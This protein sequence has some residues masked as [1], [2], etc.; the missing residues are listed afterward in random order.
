MILRESGKWKKWGAFDKVETQHQNHV[1]LFPY[2][3]TCTYHFQKNLALHPCLGI[4]HGE[5]L[6]WCKINAQDRQVIE[7]FIMCLTMQ[8]GLFLWLQA[9]TKFAFTTLG[10]SALI[11]GLLQYKKCNCEEK[12]GFWWCGPLGKALG[13]LDLLIA[14]ISRTFGSFRGALGFLTSRTFWLFRHLGNLN[15]L[16]IWTLW[17]F[18]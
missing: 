13:H 17:A 9:C 8:E 10:S 18:W 4:Y 15:P 6:L 12:L 7:T 5:F 3:L 11:I 14:W 2:Y 16:A 1:S